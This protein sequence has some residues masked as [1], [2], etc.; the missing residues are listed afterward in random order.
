MSNEAATS[1]AGGARRLQPRQVPVNSY[2]DV[3]PVLKETLRK[4]EHPFIRKLEEK[5][6]LD[7]EKLCYIVCSAVTFLLMCS[8]GNAFLCTLIGVAYPAYQSLMSIRTKTDDTQWLMYWCLFALFSL[9]DNSFAV[10]LPLYALV[11]TIILLYLALPQTYGAHNIYVIYV[12]PMLDW[13]IVRITAAIAL[14]GVSCKKGIE[15]TVNELIVSS[16]EDVPSETRHGFVNA[17]ISEVEMPMDANFHRHIAGRD[18]LRT[19]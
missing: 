8:P 14:M 18:A 16:G 10:A 19:S 6:G 17:V 12:D 2:K 7:R 5:T 13:A 1:A 3:L 15:S 11:K 9:C 4:L